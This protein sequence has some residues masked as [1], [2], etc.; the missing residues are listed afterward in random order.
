MQKIKLI[1]FV[2]K[3]DDNLCSTTIPIGKGS[4]CLALSLLVEKI[5]LFLKGG[6]VNKGYVEKQNFNLQIDYENK[7]NSIFIEHIDDDMLPMDSY[8]N[9]A[10]D[11]VDIFKAL[12]EIVGVINS[13]NVRSGTNNRGNYEYLFDE[14]IH[15]YWQRDESRILIQNHKFL[16]LIN[17]FIE[18]LPTLPRTYTVT[19]VTLKKA[20]N[21]HE[22]LKI[23]NTKLTLND[24]NYDGE[25]Y[26]SIVPRTYEK[27]GGNSEIVLQGPMINIGCPPKR[28]IVIKHKGRNQ[29]ILIAMNCNV[30]SEILP[31]GAKPT[32]L[33]IKFYKKD[34]ANDKYHIREYA[35]LNSSLGL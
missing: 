8:I 5:K 24:I 7:T 21:N 2:I 3:T 31:L 4:Y 17:Y 30:F 12:N 29:K 23:D 18:I 22:F 26:T 33:R 28:S 25:L 1:E 19:N 10:Y 15:G 32:S 27:T 34:P 35:I 6:T 9:L 11:F 20:A 14:R 13:F 16:S